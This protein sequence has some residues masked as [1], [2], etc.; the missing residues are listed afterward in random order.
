MKNN[1]RS[2]VSP[3]RSPT[4]PSASQNSIPKR[5]MWQC[6]TP[7]WPWV[8]WTGPKT[9]VQAPDGPVQESVGHMIPRLDPGRLIE[10]LLACLK[11]KKRN[12][13]RHSFQFDVDNLISYAWFLS[14]RILQSYRRFRYCCS[15]WL[16]YHTRSQLWL[17][18]HH[19]WIA[20]TGR[21]HLHGSQ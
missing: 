14:F 2:Q 4:Q 9:R 17:Q 6:H 19:P 11:T 3:Q 16:K 5:S 1:T 21:S 13:L 18:K 12:S 8:G 7:V 10:V 20:S 15:F